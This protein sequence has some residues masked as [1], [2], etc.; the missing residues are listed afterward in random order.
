MDDI[1][2]FIDNRALDGFLENTMNKDCITRSCAECGYC[3]RVAE[4]VVKIPAQAREKLIS[5]Y[6]D[7]MNTLNHGD[8]FRYTPSLQAARAPSPGLSEK[9]RK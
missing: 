3:S 4:Q 7:F 5:A 8:I 1:D 9:K 2:I 6:R